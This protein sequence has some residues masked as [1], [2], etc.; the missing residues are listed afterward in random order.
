MKKRLIGLVMVWAA[1]GVHAGTIYSADFSVA[2]QGCTHTSADGFSAASPVDGENWTLTYDST[3]VSSDTTLNEFI[4]VDGKMRV[5]DWGGEGTITSDTI[6]IT[7]GGTVNISGSGRG[8]GSDAFNYVGKEGITWFYKI[9][10]NDPVEVFLGETELGGTN[11]NSKTEVGY[12][13]SGIEVNLNDQLRVGFAVNV[14]GADT[15]VEIS[16][17]TV[18]GT[19]AG[20]TSSG[21]DL[22]AFQTADG[23]YVEFVAYDVEADGSIRLALLDE[24]GKVAWEGLVDV[25][26]GPQ[27]FARF[28]VPGLELGRSYDF[29]VRD[30]VGKWWEAAGVTVQPFAAEMTGAT[31]AG[32]TLAF[33]SQP[34]RDYE[35]QW[36][37][38]LG[39]TWQTVTNTTA[40]G[41][42]TSLGVPHPDPEGPCG[43][44][45]VQL[46]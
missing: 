13:F 29:R 24:V 37:A 15:G 40:T 36:V 16:S 2:G 46:K 39:D 9:N 27:S 5:Q 11:V 6:T 28:L 26:V 14:D 3:S 33:D 1:G 21:I 42:Q 44:F 20:V 38:A 8:V 22:R 18:D 35:I 10:D 19:A 41:S 25:A 30:E 17:L 34:D 7:Q 32:I 23:V 45:R 12:T 31:L 43:F 4:T